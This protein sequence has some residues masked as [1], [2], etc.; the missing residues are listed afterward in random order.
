MIHLAFPLGTSHGWGVCGRMLARELSRLAPV[1]LY[2]QPM[3]LELLEDELEYHALRKLLPPGSD[4]L[5]PP[6]GR[7]VSGP[8]LQGLPKLSEISHPAL[9]GSTN[10]A[11][12]FFEHDLLAGEE[13]ARRT[14]EA[15]D[16][17]ATGCT[18][19]AEVLKSH[20]YANVSTVLQGVDPRVFNP[21]GN[22]KQY[23]QDRFVVFSGGQLAIRKGQDLVIRAYQIFQERH[24]DAFLINAWYSQ[25]PEFAA[26]IQNSPY[27]QVPDI[28]GSHA[29]VV[30][31]LLAHN[32]VDLSR[33]LTLG[34]RPNLF[35][36]RLYKNSDVGLFPN[37]CEGGTNLV[38][39]E[40]MACGKPAIASFNTGHMD[41]LTDANSLPLRKQTPTPVRSDTQ[42][43]GTWYESDLE[44]IVERLEWAYNHRGALAALGAQAA[45]DLSKLA[46]EKTA[47]EFANLLGVTEHAG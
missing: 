38:L 18:W 35:M 3:L 41:I 12:T 6:P 25:W 24:K 10:V 43:L 31:T 1:E 40:Y 26:S 34:P 39:C 20:G 7:P 8:V 9:R 23:L 32:G 42:A 28:S 29:D 2:T 22:E 45:Q 47:R 4:P 30:N 15:F 21:I 5:Q 11:Y 19:C 37:R 46:W 17:I 27:L 16:R 36:S 14:L 44:E 33:V 13:P